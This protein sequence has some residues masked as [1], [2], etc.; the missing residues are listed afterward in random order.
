MYRCSVHAPVI[1]GRLVAQG[2]IRHTPPFMLFI[3]WRR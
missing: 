1:T 2:Q 3:T